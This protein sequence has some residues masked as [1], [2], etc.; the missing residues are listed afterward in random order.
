ML[1][2][3][4]RYPRQRRIKMNEGEIYW[5]KFSE[6]ERLGHEIKKDRPCVIIRN[7][8]GKGLVFVVPLSTSDNRA[9][10]EYVVVIAPSKENGLE[11]FSVAI[12]YQALSLAKDRLIRKSGNL[13][14]ETLILIKE[15]LKKCL[16]L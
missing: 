14:K 16:G 8:V 6:E 15:N 3:G 2:N 10:D 7:F 4:P 1:K 5:V 13:D 12:T 9:D 11:D